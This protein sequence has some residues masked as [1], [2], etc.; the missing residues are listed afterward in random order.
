MKEKEGP[1]KVSMTFYEDGMGIDTE[2]LVHQNGRL[3][4]QLVFLPGFPILGLDRMGGS[5]I[6]QLL[7]VAQRYEE[8]RLGEPRSRLEERRDRLVD[9]LT[10]ELVRA[11]SQN[12]FYGNHQEDD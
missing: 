2:P 8:L 4:H 1:R 3:N 9:H 12:G 7:E 11:I 5:A 6:G 10:D